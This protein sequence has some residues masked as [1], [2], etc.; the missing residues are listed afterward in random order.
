[1]NCE[2]GLIGEV[3]GHNVLNTG[4]TFVFGCGAVKLPVGVVNNF[5]NELV[6]RQ[7]K[8]VSAQEKDYHRVLRVL[9]E[10]GYDLDKKSIANILSVFGVGKKA[11]KKTVKKK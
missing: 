6:E 2:K 10:Q 5:L 4:K 11:P 8:P 3:F 1:M 7:K 9:D